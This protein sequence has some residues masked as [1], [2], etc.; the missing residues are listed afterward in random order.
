[1]PKLRFLVVA[2]ISALLVMGSSLAALAATP[3]EVANVVVDTGVWLDPDVSI[4]ATDAS[5]AVTIGRSDGERFMLAVLDED[6]TGGATAFADAVF[7]RLDIDGLLLVVTPS[8]AGFAGNNSIY[9]PDEVDA[10]LDVAF[11]VGGSDAQFVLAFAA[12]LADEATPAT[13]DTTVDQTGVIDEPEPATSGGGGGGGVLLV[14]LIVLGVG[15]FLWYRSKKNQA[16][17]EVETSLDEARAEIRSQLGEVANDVLD[18]EERVRVAENREA[19]EHYQAASAAFAEASDR[20]DAA[21]SF[22]DLEDIANDL[23]D[24]AWRLDAAEALVEGRSVPPKPTREEP[25]RCFFDPAHRP[26]YEDA[27]IKTPAGSQTVK[28]CRADAA[29]LRQGQQPQSRMI[30]VGGRQVPAAQA[31]RSYGGLGMGGLDMFQMVLGGLAANMRFGNATRSQPQPRRSARSS[32]RSGG[33]GGFF[34]GGIGPGK[35]GGSGSSSRSTR[36]SGSS[37]SSRS[38]R[39]TGSSRSRSSGRIRGGG[40]RKR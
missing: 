15:G 32:N 4:S 30:N 23:D 21:S 17:E 39:S 26:P 11:D 40:R 31:P 19:S 5:T 14:V 13:D 35:S 37:R 29:R 24:A 16:A 27:E 22:N 18:L 36:S 25:G 33:G 9:S 38:S 7:D 1:M 28:V 12:A 6:P 10:A 2:V 34:G 20:L 3:D 8:E